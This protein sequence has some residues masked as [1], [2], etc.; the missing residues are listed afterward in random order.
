MS[1]SA[2]LDADEV[3]AALERQLRLYE[4]DKIG[5]RLK[6]C[7]SVQLLTC[8][9]YAIAS[10]QAAGYPFGGLCAASAVLA[11]WASQHGHRLVLR[12]SLL[13]SATTV[14]AAICLFKAYSDAMRDLDEERYHSSHVLLQCFRMLT[15]LLALLQ[16]PI[17]RACA[18]LASEPLRRAA[19]PRAIG[20]DESDGGGE[21]E[22]L[23]MNDEVYDL[24]HIDLSRTPPETEGQ[25]TGMLPMGTGQGAG[26]GRHHSVNIGAHGFG[27][28]HRDGG[29]RGGIRGAIS[30][31]Q[32]ETEAYENAL[33][34]T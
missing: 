8:L 32:A 5:C 17:M 11:F 27:G 29:A 21:A 19:A 22:M 10:P 26:S 9:W 25:G 6:L 13:L 14:V 16:I 28:A 12:L 20:D 31:L 23:S 24:L 18:A 30:H 33:K 34:M 7:C 15:V 4:R 1:R 3:A 2:D